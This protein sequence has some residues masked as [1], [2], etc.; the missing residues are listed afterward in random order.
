[1]MRVDIIFSGIKDYCTSTHVGMKDGQRAWSPA[2]TDKQT[3]E[4]AE[5]SIILFTVTQYKEQKEKPHHWNQR[6]YRVMINHDE[7]WQVY[8]VFQHANL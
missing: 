6:V 5:I 7:S 4:T 8:S 3:T 2:Q 1:M